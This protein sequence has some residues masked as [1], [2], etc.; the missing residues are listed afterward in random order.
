MSRLRPWCALLAVIAL[1]GAASIV[2]AGED[3]ITFFE[4]NIRPLLSERCY[5]CHDA[6]AGKTKGA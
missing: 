6:S 2:S 4:R 3:G 1:V 5:K